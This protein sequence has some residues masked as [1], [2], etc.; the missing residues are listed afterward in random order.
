MLI[1]N[2][3]DNFWLPSIGVWDSHLLTLSVKW[4]DEQELLLICTIHYLDR[5]EFGVKMS[6]EYKKKS[7][8]GHMS[9]CVDAAR[10]NLVFTNKSLAPESSPRILIT[11]C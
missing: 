6:W 2:E 1:H 8:S 9:W 7:E 11:N 10:L 3:L 5:A 4:L